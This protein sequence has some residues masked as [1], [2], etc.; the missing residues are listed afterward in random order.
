MYDQY[1]I[2]HYFVKRYIFKRLFTLT[3]DTWTSAAKQSYI[4]LTAHFI[5]DDWELESICL[6]CCNFTGTHT[7][8]DYKRKVEEMLDNCDCKW[9]NV[10][11][12]VTDNEPTM[13]KFGDLIEET[14]W[15]GCFDHI[16]Q[17]ITKPVFDGPGVADL[18]SK[19]RDLCGAFNSSTQLMDRLKNIQLSMDA[20]KP[21]LFS[22]KTW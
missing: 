22:Y 15:L 13:N 12:V 9:A 8:V 19:V 17:L 5:N 20:E 3:T 4:A 21:A 7:A 10:L 11:A 16:I 1:Q 2:I 14:E 18:M 6:D